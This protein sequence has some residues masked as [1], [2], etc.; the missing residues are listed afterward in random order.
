[1]RGRTQGIPNAVNEALFDVALILATGLFRARL[2]A[3]PDS[4]RRRGPDLADLS[5]RTSQSKTRGEKA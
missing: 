1:M 5:I 4:D 2:R 3:L